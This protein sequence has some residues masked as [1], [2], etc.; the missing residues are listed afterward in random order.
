MLLAEDVDLLRI[1]LA[2]HIKHYLFLTY[3][4][5]PKKNKL[6]FM[7]LLPLEERDGR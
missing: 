1:L 4:H 2:L 5:L 7:R 6:I 3:N